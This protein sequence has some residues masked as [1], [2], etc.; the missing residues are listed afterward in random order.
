MLKE[1]LKKSFENAV[2]LGQTQVSEQHFKD[3]VSICKGCELMGKV[4]PL[5]NLVFNEGCT[6]CSCPLI[7][8]AKLINHS[9]LGSASCELGNWEQIDKKY[10]ENSKLL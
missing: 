5:P 7:T 2:L 1:F 10:N 6:K 8:K 9:I 3:R 4:E